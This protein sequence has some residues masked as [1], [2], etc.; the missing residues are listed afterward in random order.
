VITIWPCH[1]REKQSAD[2]VSA[3]H[4]MH[5]GLTYRKEQFIFDL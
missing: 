1:V 4:A 2:V 3:W 5:I